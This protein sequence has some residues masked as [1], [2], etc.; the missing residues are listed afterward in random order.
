[1]F[2]VNAQDSIALQAG[3]ATTQFVINNFEVW[4]CCRIVEDQLFKVYWMDLQGVVSLLRNI[5]KRLRQARTSYTFGCRDRYT[6]KCCL[7]H[8][9][10]LFSI[11]F[12]LIQFVY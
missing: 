5:F 6:N 11:Y 9:D 10:R 2:S 4:E 7:V 1:M 12:V 3:I 8:N